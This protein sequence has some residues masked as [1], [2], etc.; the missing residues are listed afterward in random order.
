[1]EQSNNT[2]KL[3][4]ALL[5]GAAVGG[6]LGVLFA[7]GKGS[8]TRQK[9]AAKGEGLTDTVKEKLNDLL[10]S[11]RNEVKTVKDKANEFLDNGTAKADKFKA[12]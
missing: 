4:G 1:M 12:N 8:D 7:P 6:I 3:I 2:G 10:E 9:L 11:V 5:V